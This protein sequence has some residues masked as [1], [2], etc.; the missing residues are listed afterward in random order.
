MLMFKMEDDGELLKK[1]MEDLQQV[2]AQWVEAGLL[3]MFSGG[4]I[5]VL[6]ESKYQP[7]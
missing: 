4:N 6:D 5:K 3:Q 2:Y 7:E 1:E